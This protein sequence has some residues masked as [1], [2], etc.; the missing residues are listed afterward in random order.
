VSFAQFKDKG[1]LPEELVS[2]HY[3]ELGM[4]ACILPVAHFYH[5]GYMSTYSKYFKDRHQIV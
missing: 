4:Y 3:K 2:I 5:I 1:K